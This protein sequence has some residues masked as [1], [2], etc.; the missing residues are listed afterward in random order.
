LF[1][2]LLYV[3]CTT[4]WSRTMVAVATAAGALVTLLGR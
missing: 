3:T 4:V 1:G 2:Y